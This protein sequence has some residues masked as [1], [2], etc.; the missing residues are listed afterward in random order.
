MSLPESNRGVG[1]LGTIENDS[2]SERL[3]ARVRSHLYLRGCAF[4]ELQMRC[5][6]ERD[7]FHS[8][9]LA[10]EICEQITY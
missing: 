9:H 4:R 7:H 8:K 6:H 2:V 1:I 3:I 5:E 10:E